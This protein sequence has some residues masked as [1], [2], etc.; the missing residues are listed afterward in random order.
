M[1][2]DPLHVEVVSADRQVW[3]GDAVNVIART[4]EGDIGILPGHEPVLALLQPCAVE[5]V[6]NDG[7]SE[8][9]AVD[10]GFISVANGRVSVLSQLALLGHEVG[11]EEA[12]DKAT[13]LEDKALRGQADEDELHRLRILQAQIKAGKASRKAE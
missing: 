6:T 12:I 3:S 7:R 2:R 9:V 13:A 11:L 1:A 4:V 5:I 8:T 10:G